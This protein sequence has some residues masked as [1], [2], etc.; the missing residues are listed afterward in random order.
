MF[1][2]ESHCYYET[3]YFFKISNYFDEDFFEV[4]GH[5]NIIN[6]NLESDLT[7]MVTTN[8]VDG[9][10]M[11]KTRDNIADMSWKNEILFIKLFTFL[12]IVLIFY[13]LVFCCNFCNLNI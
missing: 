12:C 11:T 1:K 9:D 4:M 3:T 13:V 8:M 7:D 2:K 5:A 10:H 6:E